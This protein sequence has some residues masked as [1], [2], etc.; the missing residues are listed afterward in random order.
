MRLGRPKAGWVRH[1]SVLSQHAPVG[2]PL[3]RLLT[4][5]LLAC[6]P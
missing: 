3:F 6:P 4:G 2:Y 1:T 5:G